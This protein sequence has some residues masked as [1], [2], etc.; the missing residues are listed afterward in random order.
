MTSERFKAIRLYLGMTQ[1][2]FAEF[3]GL[4][5]AVVGMVETSQRKV[6]DN[7]AAKIA[8]K[9]EV[10]D[11]FIEFTQNQKKLES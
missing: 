4:S 6:S 5:L 10:T 3:F 11:G 8:M 7:T 2:D 9:F 1:K